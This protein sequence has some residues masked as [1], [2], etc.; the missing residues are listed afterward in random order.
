MR[1]VL[2][3][4]AVRLVLSISVSIW[5]AGGCLLGCS[6]SA[7]GAGLEYEAESSTQPSVKAESCHS[8]QSHHCC[9]GEKPKNEKPKKKIASST[10]QPLGVPSFAP[11]PRGMI[12]DCPLV[13]NATAVT[14]KN[15]THLPDAGR[16]PVSAL[17]LIENK[18]EQS[19]PS[20]VVS[21]LP[22]RG[23]THLRCCVFLI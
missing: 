9:A 11:T 15:S 7:I 4:K 14:S 23:P 1:S 12:K 19:N 20:L 22:N 3:N 21:F 13:V 2:A 5:M 18:T 16:A 8:A 6:N 17:P 10:K